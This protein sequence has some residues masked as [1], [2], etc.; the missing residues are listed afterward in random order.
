MDFSI[1]SSPGSRCPPGR[2]EL[3]L[4]TLQAILHQGSGPQYPHARK[5]CLAAPSIDFSATGASLVSLWTSGRDT[6]ALPL[7]RHPPLKQHFA[8]STDAGHR[9]PEDRKGAGSPGAGTGSASPGPVLPLQARPL[10]A[11]D[12]TAAVRTRK[13]TELAERGDGPSL[14][15][16]GKYSF[17][18]KE[19]PSFQSLLPLKV[20]SSDPTASNTVYILR[21]KAPMYL[22]TDHLHPAASP[23]GPPDGQ[24]T[25]L[26]SSLL[27][28]EPAPHRL[29]A[30]LCYSCSSQTLAVIRDFSLTTPSN[31]SA[32]SVGSTRKIH[33]EQACFSSPPLLLP[34]SQPPGLAPRLLAPTLALLEY[35]HTH[36]SC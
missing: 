5:T 12:A 26:S 22:Q 3:P 15:T 31:L 14:D 6:Q 32:A 7:S 9:L 30:A 34:L 19:K 36:S 17:G 20:I 18:G 1:H 4:P 10:E 27:T 24:Q 35:M 25:Q 11:I 28:P 16:P 8:S 23:S 33:Q 29:E 13:Q 21:E 2:A